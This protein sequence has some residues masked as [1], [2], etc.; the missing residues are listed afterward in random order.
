MWELSG[1]W[2]DTR[3]LDPGFCKLALRRSA[4]VGPRNPPPPTIP[5][6]LSSTLRGDAPHEGVE[7]TFV[8]YCGPY[9]TLPTLYPAVTS[10]SERPCLFPTSEESP[11]S[12]TD[13]H[14]E[15]LNKSRRGAIHGFSLSSA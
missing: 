14:V 8:S 7:L 9:T 5:E 10:S 13:K 6:L 1:N 15:S 11:F 4:A 2:E 3:S 12:S